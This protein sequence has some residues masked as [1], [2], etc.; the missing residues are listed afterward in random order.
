MD[1]RLSF[2]ASRSPFIFH[3]LSQA[4]VVI[5]WTLNFSQNYKQC[6]AAMNI[7]LRLLRAL[8]FES[9]SLKL[10]AQCRAS[11]SIGIAL[12]TKT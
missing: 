5:M 1:E 4:M 11:H 7:Q 6:L 8:G 2:G 3:K 12:Y 10:K 9:A